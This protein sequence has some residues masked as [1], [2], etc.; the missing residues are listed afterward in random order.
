MLGFRSP[1]LL[2][3][4]L[5]VGRSNRTSTE[6]LVLHGVARGVDSWQFISRF[7]F[8]PTASS[9]SA[10]RWT[11]TLPQGSQ[12]EL[13]LYRFDFATWRTF[14]R[15]PMSCG[16][17][18]R[19]SKF[20]TRFSSYKQLDAPLPEH[21]ARLPAAGG[22]NASALA[23]HSGSVR[24][25]TNFA[26]VWFIAFAHCQSDAVCNTS[27]SCQAPLEVVY[28]LEMT[29]GGGRGQRHF[30]ADEHGVYT[31]FIAF[32]VLQV[33]L[34]LGA[35]HVH[36]L[37]RGHSSGDMRHFTFGILCASVAAQTLAC[38]LGL[39]YYDGIAVTGVRD[40]RLDVASQLL[41]GAADTLLL[42]LIILLAKGLT[43]VRYKISAG[44]RVK[45]AAC[46]AT[47]A[48]LL[49]AMVVWGEVQH[50]PGDVVYK[51]QSAPGAALVVV[52]VLAVLWLGHAGWTT[53]HQFSAKRG[54]YR[55]F[56]PAA[57]LWVLG[58]PLAVLLATS[59]DDWDRAAAVNGIELA[60]TFVGQLLL[61]VMYNPRCR[62]CYVD[63]RSFPF[64]RNIGA[65]LARSATVVPPATRL[66]AQAAFPRAARPHLSLGGAA[67]AQEDAEAVLARV[68]GAPTAEGA[69]AAGL[70]DA[71]LRQRRSASRRIWRASARLQRAVDAV[72][73]QQGELT[74]ALQELDDRTEHGA[75][76]PSDAL[77][78]SATAHGAADDRRHGGS[79]ASGARGGGGGARVEPKTSLA[80][81]LE[82]EGRTNTAQRTTTTT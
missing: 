53:L 56:L 48:L 10:L 65:I 20:A 35:S 27:F 12:A 38:A 80:R 46:T 78:V 60:S 25:E 62:C 33:L 16:Q 77:P 23:T 54:F 75:D 74:A 24:F 82:S 17:R 29:N 68:E 31:A 73:R 26:V 59:L 72:K 36:R 71:G 28:D 15:E 79:G 69:A 44:G 11:A 6:A 51:Y 4:L 52:R 64:H 14:L 42:L 1:L 50:D 18:L 47:Y 19:A 67:P 7:T 57:A 30:P 70:S 3:L 21:V 43:I 13:L 45:I 34:L 37:L 81:I 61:T 32:L 39:A 2:L 58:L 41:S 76:L 40:R 22:R 63:T 66:R 5:L 49:L 8:L 55:K 9:S